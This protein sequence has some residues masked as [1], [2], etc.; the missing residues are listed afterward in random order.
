MNIPAWTLLNIYTILLAVLM[1]LVSGSHSTRSTS[2]RQNRSFRRMIYALLV[3][4]LLDSVSCLPD[5]F[6]NGWMPIASFARGMVRS[7][8]AFCYPLMLD[9]IDS[10]VTGK[11]EFRK[12][13]RKGLYALACVNAVLHICS[14]MFS[15]NLFNHYENN[16]YVYGKLPDYRIGLN[17]IFALS[18]ELFVFLFR[19]NIDKRFR[20]PIIFGPIV[21]LVTGLIQDALHIQVA[22]SGMILAM[23]ILYMYVQGRYLNEDFLTGGMNR[24][25]IDQTMHEYIRKDMRFGAVML[26]IDYFKTIN[27]T[28]GHTIG[29]KVLQYVYLLL[30]NSFALGDEIARYGGDEFLIVTRD[31]DLTNLKKKLDKLK[32]NIAEANEACLFDCHLSIS[33]GALVYDPK[34]KQTVDQFMKQL[35]DLLY[36]NK[37]E[38]HQELKERDEE[39]E[40]IE[41]EGA[42]KDEFAPSC[43]DPQN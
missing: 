10:L 22:F 2:T 26:D 39:I 3:L 6:G 23:L 30:Q 17:C 33:A 27:D 34:K 18:L 16:I 5:L 9:Y 29:D 4:L 21:V 13:F 1:L 38:H 32:S 7:L 8:E 28:L 43:S 15:W 37:A 14:W 31:M 42:R 40:K 20:I 25:K 35:D 24:R 11:Q 19:Q 12:A 36:E 41:E